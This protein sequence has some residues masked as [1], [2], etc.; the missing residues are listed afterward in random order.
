MNDQRCEEL[1]GELAGDE[2][3][4]LS[5]FRLMPD[6]EKQRLLRVAQHLAKHS[7]QLTKDQLSI[8]QLSIVQLSVAQLNINCITH[9][10]ITEPTISQLSK[11]QFDITQLGYTQLG[12]SHS[13]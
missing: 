3:E 13:A 5:A 4:L 1:L 7:G 8:G 12:I 9:L 10:S 11:N 2:E 6:D